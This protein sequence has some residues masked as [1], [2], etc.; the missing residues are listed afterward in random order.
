MA[1]AATGKFIA[2]FEAKGPAILA[3][4]R[5]AH[6]PISGEL[7]R[8]VSA[9]ASERRRKA[10]AILR[11]NLIYISH[12]ELIDHCRIIIEKIYHDPVPA[13]KKLLGY[14]GEPTKSS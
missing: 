5:A 11:D 2:E 14:V 4:N 8:W 10:A 13:E 3:M 6:P 12:G 7:D 9:Q 1:A